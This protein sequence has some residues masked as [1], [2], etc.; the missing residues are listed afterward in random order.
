MKKDKM[1]TIDNT[2]K[3]PK[4]DF[5]SF[6]AQLEDNRIAKGKR[7]QFHATL[8][9]ILLGVSCGHH[10]YR[11]LHRFMVANLDF[12]VK[13]FNLRHGIP[14]HV[15]IR[16]IIQKLDKD[17]TI[18]AFNKWANEIDFLKAGDRVSLDGKALCSTMEAAQ[19]HEQ[20]FVK[21]VSIY[22]QKLGLV[23]FMED[24][25][26][27]KDDEIHVVQEMINYLKDKGLVILL[28][29]LHCQKKL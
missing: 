27:K 6:M 8:I 13:I 2:D 17:K 9:M 24:Y 23:A 19:T 1:S 22:S 14:S 5:D 21:V 29:A 26:N 10:G 28:D 15:T 18:L 12:F 11:P 3:K 20:D 4:L 16:S 7:H 25:K